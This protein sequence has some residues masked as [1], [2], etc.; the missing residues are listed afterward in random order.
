MLSLT[1]RNQSKKT[2]LEN[3]FTI[4]EEQKNQKVL[5]RRKREQ[6]RR[7]KNNYIYVSMYR[8]RENTKRGDGKKQN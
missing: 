4:G 5:S 7:G 2:T 1:E 3:T 6:E 8:Y